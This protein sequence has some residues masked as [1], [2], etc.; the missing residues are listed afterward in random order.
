MAEFCAVMK[1]WGRLCSTHICYDCSEC[2]LT[3]TDVCDSYA[4]DNAQNAAEI[5]KRVMAWAK[6]HHEPQYQTWGEWLAEHGIVIPDKVGE[7]RIK[8]NILRKVTEPIP[9]DIAEK[10]GLKPKEA[11]D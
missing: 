10:L 6:E 11:N 4:K 2:V 1:Q 7:G 9:A 3:G 5:E 8:Y